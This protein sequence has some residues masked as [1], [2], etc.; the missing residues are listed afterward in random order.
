M[1][2]SQVNIIFNKETQKV[3]SEND[4]WQFMC[5]NKSDSNIICD[6]TLLLTNKSEIPLYH[7]IARQIILYANTSVSGKDISF[8]K[9]IVTTVDETT[10]KNILSNVSQIC[11]S[12]NTYGSQFE[13]SSS[14]SNPLNSWND[15]QI[16]KEGVNLRYHGKTTKKKYARKAADF[17]RE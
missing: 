17:R 15:I 8:S 9:D 5:I 13:I 3:K 12:I 14:P 1:S 2:Y 10:L 4:L 16:S 7:V 6:V 11:I